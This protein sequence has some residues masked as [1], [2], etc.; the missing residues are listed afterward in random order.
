MGIVIKKTFCVK[1]R[2]SLS[3]FAHSVFMFSWF[4]VWILVCLFAILLLFL[5]YF[6]LPCDCEIKLYILQWQHGRC[7]R[8]SCVLVCSTRT[9]CCMQ[10]CDF[11]TKVSGFQS[12]RVHAVSKDLSVGLEAKVLARI[13]R[14]YSQISI[15]ESRLCTAWH[16]ACVQFISAKLASAWMPA[17]SDTTVVV[18]KSASMWA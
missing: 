8:V 16:C 3:W 15:F 2:A 5:S 17:N 1:C 12:T 4:F 18:H 11:E 10:S 7:W 13:Y 14:K 9:R 6:V